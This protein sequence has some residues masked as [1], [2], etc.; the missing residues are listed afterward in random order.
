MKTLII[1]PAYNEEGC[2]VDTVNSVKTISP[3]NDYIVINDGS[4]DRTEELCRKK[5]IELI[6]LPINLG[7][8]GGFQ[9]GMKYALRHNYDAVLQFDGDG[10]HRADFIQLLIESMENTDADIVIGSRFLDCRKGFSLRMAGSSLITFLIMFTSRKKIMDPTSG[11]R[12]YSKKMIELFAT[13]HDIA[14]E[15][16]TLAYCIRKGF[17]VIEVPVEMQERLTGESYL[18]ATRS[19]I[20]MARVCVSL[21]IL[22]WFR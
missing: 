18:N 19:I 7:L 16:D 5:S 15:P 3:Q 6:S 22:Q 8:A 12:L 21:L 17:K 1:I 20:Y 14:P 4:S 2:I 13:K 11:M 10:Q 9:T